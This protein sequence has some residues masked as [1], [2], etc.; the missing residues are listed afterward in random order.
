MTNQITKQKFLNPETGKMVGYARAKTL[1]LVPEVPNHI[2]TEIADF[3]VTT[4]KV[5]SLTFDKKVFDPIKTDM[6]QLNGFISTEGG[7]LPATNTIIIGTPGIGKTTVGMDLISRC[8]VHSNAKVLFISGEMNRIDLFRYC[9]RFPQFGELDTMFLADYVKLD[10]RLAIEKV[11]KKG[12]DLVLM[13]SWAEIC[14]TIKDSTGWSSSKAQS[15]ILDLMEEHNEGRNE[16]NLFTSFLIIQ[17]VTKSG[18]FLGSN[19]LKHMTSAMLD[20]TTDRELGINTMEF[21]KN[22]SGMV[23]RKVSFT[24]LSGRIQYAN[25]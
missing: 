17:Q 24:F 11:L 20:L 16:D 2:H 12:Y 15:W 14:L 3:D 10:P 9:K 21:S 5:N 13:D 25:A 22:R 19:R 4:V 7:F 18:E 8:K 23:G 1:G 6:D